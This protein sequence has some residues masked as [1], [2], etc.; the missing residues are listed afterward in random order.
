MS[1]LIHIELQSIWQLMLVQIWLQFINLDFVGE[2]KWMETYVDGISKVISVQKQDI[3]IKR[4]SFVNNKLK[5]Y[6][7]FTIK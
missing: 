7:T 6:G 3:L 5:K 1:D 4:F 2:R